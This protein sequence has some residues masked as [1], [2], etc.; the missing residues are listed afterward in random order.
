[1]RGKATS[2]GGRIVIV[3]AFVRFHS[4]D[5]EGRSGTGGLLLDFWCGR[6]DR[7]ILPTSS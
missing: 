2:F 7:S 1:M 6:Q 5:T 3:L 4:R